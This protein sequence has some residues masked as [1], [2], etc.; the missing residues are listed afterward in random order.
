MVLSSKCISQRTCSD[1]VLSPSINRRQNKAAFSFV[2]NLII[3]GTPVLSLVAVFINENHPSILGSPPPTHTPSSSGTDKSSGNTTNTNGHAVGRSDWQ[4]FDYVLYRF[5]HA[6]DA[7]RTAMFKMIPAIA[8]GS[9]VIKQSVGTVPVL[10][11]TKLKT[12]YYQT[13]NYVESSVDV[14]SSSAAAY[15]TGKCLARWSLLCSLFRS[16]QYIVICS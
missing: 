9:W 13:A 11:G 15:I 4:P 5:L 12:T 8:E 1:I 10:L 2:V 14:T 6:D 7:E 16:V 3:P